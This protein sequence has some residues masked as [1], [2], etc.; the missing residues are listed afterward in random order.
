[1][2]R[3]ADLRQPTLGRVG[4]ARNGIVDSLANSSARLAD[5]FPLEV[6]CD[7]G[8][9]NLTVANI[10]RARGCNEKNAVTA[11]LGPL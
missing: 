11:S 4:T 8:P 6:F 7:R 9:S 5:T 2:T 1:M 3:K 10:P